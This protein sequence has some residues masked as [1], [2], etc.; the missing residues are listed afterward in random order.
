MAFK[1]RFETNNIKFLT[2][3]KPSE[4]TGKLKQIYAQVNHD[5]MLAAPFTLHAAEPDLV[6]SV[7][8]AERETMFYGIVP[9][10]HKEAV[11]SEVAKTNHCPYCI[12]AH[13]LMMQAS[14]EE[15]ASKIVLNNNGNVNDPL[16]QQRIEWGAATRTPDAPI[17]KNPPFTVEEAPEIIGGALAFHY[18]NRMVNIFIK[19]DMMPNMGAFNSI[20]RKGVSRFMMKSI[21]E[22]ELIA[23]ASLKF[24][25]EADLPMEFSWAQ[26][27]Q[28][29]S[30]SFA[31]ITAT[32]DY[33]IHQVISSN[34]IHLVSQPYNQWNGEDM[35]I[36]RKWVKDLTQNLNEKERYAANLM[37][38]AGLAPYQI[39]ETDIEL[40]RTQYPDDKQL[41]AVTSWGAWSAVKRISTWLHLPD[42]QELPHYLTT[43]T[44]H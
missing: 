22:R 9:R 43:E 28:H 42:K 15:D 35:G 11:V 21:L 16:L 19:G 31:G 12:S 32:I 23:G 41:L 39:T 1:D 34:I 3:H 13:T 38:L 36:S 26:N 37:L 33:Y 2:I 30:R 29:I 25:P 6:A 24:L 7:W 44:T 4:A 8:S 17:L 27:H 20:V 10:A 5:F 14:G 40:F 18:I